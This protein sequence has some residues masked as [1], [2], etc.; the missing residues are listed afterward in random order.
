MGLPR[1]VYHLAE[2]A[3]WPSIQRHGLLSAS[4]LL[5]QANL[6]E[7]VRTVLE[8]TQRKAHTRLPSGTELRDQLPMP[9]NALNACV[10]GLTASEWYALINRQ[11]FFW[12]DAERLNRQRKA[13]GPRPQVV[14]TIDAAAM[15]EAH[16]EAVA[17]TPINTGNARRKP[18]KRSAHTFVPYATWVSSGWASESAAVGVAVRSRTHKPVELTIADA[19][20]DIMRFVV[21]VSEVPSGQLFSPSAA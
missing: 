15:I 21:A 13:C 20:P 11:V 14:L 8:T 1:T 3:N 10:V 12:L 19:V 7:K 16:R 18:A 2:A 4:R 17:L 5:H 6:P 9:A